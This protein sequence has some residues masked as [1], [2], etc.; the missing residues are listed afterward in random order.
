MTEWKRP[1]GGGLEAFLGRTP[2]IPGSSEKVAIQV[3]DLSSKQVSIFPGSENLYSPRLS[4]DGKHLAT[5]ISDNKKL[6]I[7]DFHTHKWIDWVSEPGLID[8]PIWSRD[9]RYIDYFNPSKAPGYRRVK[10]RTN[11]L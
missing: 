11:P 5:I 4:P 10:D 7:F 8:L 1:P 9:G 2:F 3:L 6:L